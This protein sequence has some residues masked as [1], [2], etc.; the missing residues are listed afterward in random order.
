MEPTSVFQTGQSFVT[1]K[2][3][4]PIIWI[5]KRIPTYK[6][7]QKKFFHYYLIFRNNSVVKS[8]MREA[9]MAF[10]PGVL[11]GSIFVTADAKTA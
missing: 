9:G 10:D 7:M 5:K 2:N 11:Q 6:K 4:R 3:K 1:P 8:V